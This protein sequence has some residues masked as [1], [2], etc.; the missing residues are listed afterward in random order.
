MLIR[1]VIRAESDFNPD[2]TPSKGSMG[3]MQLMPDTVK[4]LGVERPYDISENVMRGT[5]YL[6]KLLDRYEGNT[7]LALAAYNWGMGNLERSTDNLPRET[8]DYIAKINKFQNSASS[9]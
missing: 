1:S 4:D 2:C 7:D 8:R 6:K 5:N 3:L 9:V